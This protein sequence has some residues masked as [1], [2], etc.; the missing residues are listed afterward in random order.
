MVNIITSI[1][2][3]MR[4]KLQ[5]HVPQGHAQSIH[6]TVFIYWV[7]EPESYTD[8]GPKCRQKG[9]IPLLIELAIRPRTKAIHHER[10]A[11]VRGDELS[12]SHKLEA[13]LARQCLLQKVLPETQIISTTVS[14][15]HLCPPSGFQAH[16]CL[17]THHL[18]WKQ[19]AY[20][21]ISLVDSGF[22]VA[23]IVT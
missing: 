13:L 14:S 19:F 11:A 20:L 22:T 2:P 23:G 21:P 4:S 1:E 12:L 8:E 10:K 18:F 9:L 15:E 7:C 17:C 3:M 6:S 5:A 16:F